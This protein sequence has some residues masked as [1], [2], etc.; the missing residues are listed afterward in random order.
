MGLLDDLVPVAIGSS[1]VKTVPQPRVKIVDA[2][3]AGNA[4]VDSPAANPEGDR[5]PGRKRS[6]KDSGGTVTSTRQLVY[7]GLDIAEQRD[8]TNGVVRRY[9]ADGFTV[10]AQPST[11]NYFYAKDHLGSIREVVD[12]QG[13]DRERYGYDPYGRVTSHGSRVWEVENQ[14]GEHQRMFYGAS[15]TLAVNTGDTL[16][17]YVYLDAA[18]APDQVMLQFR[19]GSSWE[20]RA[21]WGANYI[22]LGTDGTD[23]RR[24]MGALPDTGRWVRLEVPASAV[25]LEGKTLNG[26]SFTLY[27]GA[28]K[29]DRMG[30]RAAGGGGDQVWCDD[31]VP[32]G[33]T[34]MRYDGAWSASPFVWS[35]GDFRSDMLYTGHYHHAPTG[36]HLTLYRAYSPDLARWLFPDPIKEAGGVNLYAYVDNSPVNLWDPLGLLDSNNFS[37][38]DPIHNWSDAFQ[39][40]DYDYGGHGRAPKGDR[41]FDDT[42]APEKGEGPAQTPKDV[43]NDIMNDPAYGNGQGVTLLAC[44]TGMG[45]ERSFGQKLA[46]LLGAP[47]TAPRG[48]IIIDNSGNTRVGNNPVV[49]A[50]QSPKGNPGWETFY[51]R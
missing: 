48:D 34:T 39:T 22:A 33:A 20:H 2:R 4:A 45:G 28:A 23:S 31:E 12:G 15:A 44:R 36:L 24:S 27:G 16:V 25:G 51:P 6:Q 29:W 21:Y 5:L 42:N 18:V 37:P 50:G 38:N 10:N 46:N 32:A 41:I 26:V 30:K 47:V 8:G 13:V 1:E 14:A 35:Q 9:F 49:P 43:A 7:D 19:V 11:L 40:P 3:H 17:A